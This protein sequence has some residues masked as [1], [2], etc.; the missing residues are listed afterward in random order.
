MKTLRWNRIGVLLLYMV[1]VSM[2]YLANA[3]PLNG[4]TT[5]EVSAKYETLFTPA[6]Y[7]FSI[8]IV[9]Y[10]GLFVYAVYQAFFATPNQRLYDRISGWI[11]FNF[12]ANSL[13][14]PVFHYEWIAVSVWVMLCLLISLVV[15]NIRLAQ[16]TTLCVREKALLRIPFGIYFGWISVATIANVSILLE[17][18]G[19]QAWG[20][21]D[22]HWAVIMLIVGMLITFFVLYTLKAYWYALVL[23]WAYLAIVAKSTG[24]ELLLQVAFSMAVVIFVVDLLYFLK[25]LT[26]H[27]AFS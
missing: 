12:V 20:L 8:W 19:W 15:I 16:D 3:L 25:Q 14:L 13:W 4:Q 6:S 23:V 2:N 9:I 27:K 26:K 11:M 10:L 17:D 24:Y 21:S 22:L 5:G 1:M 7:A 18:I